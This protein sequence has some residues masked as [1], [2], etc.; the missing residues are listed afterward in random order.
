MLVLLFKHFI[1]TISNRVC[2]V[3]MAHTY[4]PSY[5]GSRD[6]VDCSWRR[7][8]ATKMR[9]YLK[10][11]PMKRRAGGV[12]QVVECLPSKHEALSSK[13]STKKKVEQEQVAC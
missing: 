12:D 10:K 7:V 1:L 8:Q 13:P 6:Q 3:P 4:N 2:H 11:N 9:T 5:L